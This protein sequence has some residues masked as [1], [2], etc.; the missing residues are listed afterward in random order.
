ML[1]TQGQ[2][3]IA[4]IEGNAQQTISS[5]QNAINQSASGLQG[6]LQNFQAVAKTAKAPNPDA[7]SAAAGQAE[8]QIDG[9]IARIQAQVE[10]G[11]T[12]SVQSITQSSQ[13]SI[14]SF[15]AI[16]QGAIATIT[17]LS[18]GLTT[19]M[20]GLAQSATDSFTQIKDSHTKKT[21]QTATTA[22][23]GFKKQTDGIKKTFQETSN[24]LKDQFQKSTKQIETG[25]RGA[26]DKLPGDIEHEAEDAA[27]KV[28]PTKELFKLVLIVVVVVVAALVLGPFV[29][30]FLAPF[31]LGGLATAVIT[32]AV[33]GAVSAAAIKIGSDLIDNN[34]DFSKIDWK[35]VAKATAIGG[36]M[37]A[38]GGGVGF[39][40]DK[41]ASNLGAQA[42]QGFAGKMALDTGKNVVGGVVTELFTGQF[43]W[44][45]IGPSLL[46]AVLT[47]GITS[48]K[49]GKSI[50][51]GNDARG[52]QI[53]NRV[54]SSI[55]TT[56]GNPSNVSVD[57]SAP[58]KPVVEEPTL[59]K[60]VVEEPTLNKPVVEEP[61]LN[62]PVVEEPT[63]NKPVVEEPTPNKPVVEEP[64]PNK[65]VVEEP[66]PNKPVVEEPTPNKPVV[67]EPT[68][69]K[70]V[71]E[72]P[73]PNKRSTHLDEP[74]VE[75]GVVAKEPTADGD[76]QIKILRDGRIVRC[77]DCAT[78]RNDYAE[79]LA[80]NP[81]LEEQLQKIEQIVDP[82]EKLAESVKFEEKLKRIRAVK[83][84]VEDQTLLLGE[85]DFSLS[86][87][88]TKQTPEGDRGKITATTL[89]PL[90]ELVYA[91]AQSNIK[92][93][94]NMGATVQGGIDATKI[95]ET[96]KDKG[97]FDTIAWNFPHAKVDRKISMRF[98]Q[99]L[100][101]DFFGSAKGVLKEAGKVYVTLKGTSH[102]KGWHIE[103]QA[104]AHGFST[105]ETHPIPYQEFTEAY[106]GYDHRQTGSDQ[107]AFT[108]ETPTTTY[109]FKL[110]KKVNSGETST[111]KRR[112][113]E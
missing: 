89:E 28:D 58:N 35:G 18:Q 50:I 103:E 77:S 1:T 52:S 10:Q 60:P 78:I 41:I 8:G 5:L 91:T 79:E 26:L 86:E 68:P 107:P 81:K 47:A 109:I 102:Y 73:T 72:E 57:V 7:L 69:N 61:T 64:T 80:Q 99:K 105:V 2:Q 17:T 56:L 67:E 90:D 40:I 82:K 43:Q 95:H 55:D 36:L 12:A 44:D 9:E 34:G 98:H 87:S 75:P 16:G 59:N 101:N 27:A 74:E 66:T 39:G 38:V 42:I 108:P 88:L 37:G 32:G 13:Q 93:L 94:E 3:Q 14:A 112:R 97:G 49:T 4:A 70:P 11:I 104:A 15:A 96:F 20:T 100:L 31:A 29:A 24:S 71:V 110:T 84:K 54:K 62:K 63:P 30:G 113:I 51:E 85:G 111:A 83:I 48:S 6:S 46:L 45:N 106:S 25:L 76:H 21:T 22:L 33:V 19:T 23:D 65:P 53:G 92:A